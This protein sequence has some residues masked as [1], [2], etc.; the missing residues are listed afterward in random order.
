MSGATTPIPPPQDKRPIRSTTLIG[1]E[2][3]A[4]ADFEGSG[5]LNVTT[6]VKRL[7]Q[8]RETKKTIVIRDRSQAI[9]YSRILITALQEIVDYDPARHHN[10]PPPDLYVGNDKY[11]HEIR[12]LIA[13]LRTLNSLLE[14]KRP[15]KKKVSV[16]TV[17]LKVHVNAFLKAHSKVLGAGTAGLL[18][19]AFSS[20]LHQLGLGPDIVSE[21]LNHLKGPH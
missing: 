14:A 6:L 7:T 2:L 21:I 9:Q 1:G 17:D 13:E 20:L 12:A 15:T 16:V 19:G 18:I 11:L 10:Q 5:S 4:G 8:K 3:S